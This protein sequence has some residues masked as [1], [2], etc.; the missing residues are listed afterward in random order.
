MYALTSNFAWTTLGFELPEPMVAHCSVQI[1]DNPPTI[2]FIGGVP[3]VA[4][5]NE[6]AK[7]EQIH[8]LNISA[9]GEE[10]STGP[11]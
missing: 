2:A 7:I 8:I 10:W 3:N 1:S 9:T 5:L 4:N 11:T 6:D